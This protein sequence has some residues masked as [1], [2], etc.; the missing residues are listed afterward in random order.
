MGWSEEKEEVVKGNLIVNRMLSFVVASVLAQLAPLVFNEL[1]ILSCV[2]RQ[3]AEWVTAPL[4][5]F[6]KVSPSC[7]SCFT[8]W[9]GF[10][11][12]ECLDFEERVWDLL[13]NFDR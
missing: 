11:P 7:E 8:G 12:C 6:E 1:T 4:F 5:V 3:F 10:I 9:V 13:L 2:G